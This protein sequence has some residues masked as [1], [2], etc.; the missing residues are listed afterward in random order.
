MTAEKAI[1]EGRD[2]ASANKA[3]FMSKS[4]TVFP[5][6]KSETITLLIFSFLDVHHRAID[7]LKR[8]NSKGYDI[9]QKSFSK[10]MFEV[11]LKSQLMCFQIKLFEENEIFLKI[12]EGAVSGLND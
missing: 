10:N 7:F 6:V 5:N 9:S 2:K 4:R 1:K 3:F 8:L 12:Y 11:Y